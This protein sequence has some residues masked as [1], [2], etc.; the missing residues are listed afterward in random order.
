MSAA[1]DFGLIGLGV[2]GKNL[3]LNI[4]DHGY[5]VAAW[6]L[7]F[8]QGGLPAD[9][10]TR[11]YRCFASLAE[12]T[13]ALTKPRRILIMIPAGPGLDALLDKLAALCSSGDVLIDG[14][15]TWFEDTRQREKRLAARGLKFF[16]VGVSG[17][18]EGARHGP[19]LMPGGDAEGYRTLAPIL[20][21]IAAKTEDGPCV[22]HVGPDGAGHYVK[23]VHNGIEY[24]DMQCIAEAYDL[25]H[26]GLGLGNAQLAENFERWNQGALQSFLI[27]ITAKILRFPDGRGG[28]LVDRV[29]DKAGQKGTGRWTVQAALDL[30]VAIPSIAA[31]LDA[32]VLSSQRDLRQNF[33]AQ[34][35]LPV[36]PTTEFDADAVHDALLLSKAAAYAQGFELLARASEQYQWGLRLDELARI[37]KG[38]C[39]I[40]ARFLDE[41][42]RAY[43]ANP[44]LAHL[45]LAPHFAE[46][47]RRHL[48]TLARV[49]AGAARAGIP[50][51]A[52]AASLSTLQALLSPRLPQNLV[53][54]QRDAFGGH[55]YQTV[56]DP[57]GP[58]VHSN[59]LG[60]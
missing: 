9:S 16:G 18:E 52:F 51:P 21:A 6:D 7:K 29:L 55:T 53:Q 19:A 5:R 39:I 4:A 49:V 34:L 58:F 57:A 3:A 56:D 38:G 48:P 35:R 20:E 23:M 41:I 24:A 50:V 54:A 13:A 47:S 25:M 30:G 46:L 22:T 27:E 42:R 43:Q 12:L 36:N 15:N 8:E 2:M 37:W 60:Q 45:L 59:W 14:G 11:P 32:R 40:R 26:R 10:Q 33:A 1:C 31:A 28:H 17:G 44:K